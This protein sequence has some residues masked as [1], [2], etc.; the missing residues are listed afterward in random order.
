MLG[1][2]ENIIDGKEQVDNSSEGSGSLRHKLSH[3]KKIDEVA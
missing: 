3:D 2:E 1:R